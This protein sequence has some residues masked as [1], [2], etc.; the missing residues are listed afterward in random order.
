LAEHKHL[1]LGAQIY[2]Y[3]NMGSERSLTKAII[4]MVFI[5]SMLTTVYF[6]FF[7]RRDKVTRH[8][9]LCG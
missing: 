5:A 9:V 8:A 4:A 3:T 2:P 1:C 6:R 7:H